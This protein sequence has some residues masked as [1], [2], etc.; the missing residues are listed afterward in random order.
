MHFSFPSFYAAPSQ[1]IPEPARLRQVKGSLDNNG[2]PLAPCSRRLKLLLSC[3]FALIRR[4]VPS[5]VLFL[6]GLEGGL[7]KKKKL[8]Q[9]LVFL[10]K[11][12]GVEWC[13]TEVPAVVSRTFNLSALLIFLWLHAGM[14]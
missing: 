9:S 4:L 14:S 5:L 1:H 3:L 11:A 8:Y 2:H 12:L 13:C 10:D 6:L 7:K